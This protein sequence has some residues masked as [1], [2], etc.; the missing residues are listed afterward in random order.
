MEPLYK[1]PLIVSK[2]KIGTPSSPEFKVWLR[3]EDATP[4]VKGKNIERAI[5]PKE[6]GLTEV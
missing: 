4:N 5:G 3:F 1:E 6:W 2:E